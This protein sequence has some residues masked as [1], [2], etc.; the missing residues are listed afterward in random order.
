MPTQPISNHSSLT[1]P[2]PKQSLPK[3][4]AP[5]P[6]DPYGYLLVHFKEDPNGYAERIYLDLSDGDNPRRWIP[7]NGGEPILTSNIGTTG[8]RDPHIIRNPETGVWTIIATD[9][10][11]FGGP[12]NEQF[13]RS[14]RDMNSWY[15]W[16]HYGST[17]LMIWQ[18]T[19]LVHWQG[20]RPLDVSRSNDG[21]HL[22]FGMAWACECLWVPNYYALAGVE[23]P[24]YVRDGVEKRAQGAFVIYWSSKVFDDNDTDHSNADVYDTVQWGVTHDFTQ[25]TYT[26]GGVFIDTGGSSID[27]T[28]VQRPLPD[29]GKRTYRITKDNSFGRGIWMDYT[30]AERWWLPSVKWQTIQDKLGANYAH[31]ANPGGVEGPAV[32]AS[33]SSEEWYLFVDV[34]PE[35][36]YR[37]MISRDLDAGFVPLDDPA[38]ALAPATKHGGV[39]SLTYAQYQRVKQAF[40]K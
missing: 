31:D 30:D 37:P 29:G 10:R 23:G 35:I 7:L 4:A 5:N 14:G 40:L 20:P 8:V 32:F 18:S 33:H 16:S 19:D 25:E 39:T 36:G 6:D 26:Y 22:E 24:I 2:S 38:F 28:M 3:Q 13:Q 27:T 21:K 15:Y 17:N 9:L 34:I 11:V 12:D 1:Q